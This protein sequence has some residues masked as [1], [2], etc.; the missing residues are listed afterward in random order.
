MVEPPSSRPTSDVSGEEIRRRRERA[1]YSVLT[2]AVHAGVHTSIVEA[3]ES[4]PEALWALM[5]PSVLKTLEGLEGG[6]EAAEA[7][8][9]AVLAEIAAEAAPKKRNAAGSS[10]GAGKAERG[11]AHGQE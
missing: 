2:L 8:S 3:N 1:D 9:Q 11:A 5:L 10:R 6:P 4:G 7:S